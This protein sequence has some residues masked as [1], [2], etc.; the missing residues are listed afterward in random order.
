VNHV[1]H[2]R[3]FRRWTIMDLRQYLLRMV[4]AGDDA[5]LAAEDFYSGWIQDTLGLQHG[6]PLGTC[7]TPASMARDARNVAVRPSGHRCGA[8]H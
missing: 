3:Q 4:A 5:F 6:L 1:I 2:R 8:L 7:R